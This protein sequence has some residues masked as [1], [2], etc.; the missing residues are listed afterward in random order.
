MN[1]LLIM[2]VLVLNTECVSLGEY[3]VALSYGR[4]LYVM[5]GLGQHILS[6]LP[7]YSF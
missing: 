2:L 4:V 6:L 1:S 7:R 3:D 5:V